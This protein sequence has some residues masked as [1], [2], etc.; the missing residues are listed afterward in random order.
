MTTV[1]RSTALDF[2][3]IKNNLKTYLAAQPQFTDYNFEASGLSNILDVL[4]YNT[5]INA[6]IAN[7]ALN[8]SYL[9]TA[10][11]R[12]SVVS[13]AEGIGYV[14]DTDTAAQA[15]LNISFTTSQAARDVDI[16]LPAFTQFTA[17][18]DG[19][20]YTF[21]TIERYR[22]VDDGTGFYEFLTEAG[23]NEI[24]VFE[25]TRRTKTFIVGEYE[26]NPVYVIPDTTIDSSTVVV[27]VYESVT[28]TAFSTYQNIINASAITANSTVY[29]LKEAPN[30]YFEL[31][32]GDGETFGRSPVAGNKIVV[33]Y[34]STRG[35]LANNATSFEATA[36]LVA[37]GVTTDLSVVTLSLSTG[38]RAKESIESIRKNAPFQYA[39]QNRMVTAEDYSSLILKNYSSLISD[40]KAWGGEDNPEPEYGAV[41]VSILFNN[42]VTSQT[43]STTKL[44]I[45]D[46]ADQLAILSFKIRF[47]DPEITYVEVDNFFEYNPRLT[48]LTLNTIQSN[49]REIIQNYFTTTVG[50]FEQAFRRSNMLTLIDESNQAIFSSRADIRM[51]KRFVPTT[52]SIVNTVNDLTN[53]SLST[54]L[55][56]QVIGLIVSKDYNTAASIIAKYSLSNY[57]VI[58]NTISTV[59]GNVTFNVAYPVSIAVPDDDTLTVT[60][61]AFVYNG[62]N[63]RIQ[64]KLSSN[65]LQ[66]VALGDQRIVVDNIGSYNPTAGTATIT[67]FIPS[68]ILGGVDYIKLSAVPANQSAISPIRNNILEYDAGSSFARGVQVTA[69]N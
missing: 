12:S 49:V 16:Y 47:T 67:Y 66:I 34:L 14:P 9:T 26:D 10:Q 40:I 35:E 38:G 68:S 19:T 21:Q 42:N 13:I 8:E 1:I 3:N 15:K 50:G 18:V 63:C 11:L 4:A 41:Y 61:S 6:L 30:G 27:N 56:N 33:E 55:L 28:A 2:D 31:S 58:R 23:S 45:V 57:T 64:N 60:S 65:I 51:Q 29:I 36:Q 52:P 48:P 17:E 20:T 53:F 22:A 54:E 7:F 44:Q 25:G 39:T 5:H 46:L 59:S 69:T 62:V 37:G 32:F 43:R 24:P